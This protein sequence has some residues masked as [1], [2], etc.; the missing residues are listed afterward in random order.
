MKHC[1]QAWL[2]GL[3]N[4]LPTDPSIAY[5]GESPVFGCNHLVCD[6]CG[7]VVR[8]ADRR[9]TTSNYPPP[10]PTIEALYDSP[11]P[12]SSP[13][14]NAAPV[15]E[16]SRA[17]FCR[18]DWAS[19]DLG[20]I[21]SLGDIEARW[22]CGG[23]PG[24]GEEMPAPKPPTE[25]TPPPT[26]PILAVVP[27]PVERAA[28][29][30]PPPAPPTVPPAATGPKIRIPFGRGFTPEFATASELRD[31]L[32]ASYPA[33]SYFRA[34]VVE[35]DGPDDLVSAWGWVIKLI[36]MRTD[37]WPS[38]G[39]ALQH[40]VTDGDDLART[41]FADL[42]ADY[43][44]SLVLMPWTTPLAATMPDVKSRS[45]GTGWGAPD[46]RL[47]SIVRDQQAYVAHLKATN[48]EVALL[49]YGK[50]GRLIQGPL[51]TE[52]ELRALL[53]QSAQAGQF[54]DGD[55]GP[56]SWLG[57]ELRTHD[58]ALRAAFLR[59]VPT[60]ADA[61]EPMVFALLDWL[62][63]EQDLGRLELVLTG[64]AKSPPAWASTPAKQKPRGWKRTIR[65]A[66]WPDVQTLGDVVREA[67]ARAK[68]QLATP[69]VTDL[70]LLFP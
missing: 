41:A 22:G 51:T 3:L 34:P 5:A 63:E 20:R 8:H 30:E 11:D 54:P 1:T 49:D 35:V 67:L 40:A 18:C 44:D 56:W 32:L 62:F 38:I 24:P 29:P 69:P 25:A 52:A 53:E 4:E 66:H 48:G 21:K 61:A 6:R 23:H 26:R 60:I 31:N 43:R 14:L 39:V 47:A 37:W 7:A 57:F 58:D 64:W 27:K 9:A 16:D 68:Q 59:I 33:A 36:R 46:L 70:P 42:L 17:Y 65:S 13:L 19:A 45:T 28:P 12:A 55:K 2:V 50:G 15:H 10:R